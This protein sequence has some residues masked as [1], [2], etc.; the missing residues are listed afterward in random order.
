MPLYCPLPTTHYPLPLP[1]DGKA[2][3]FFFGLTE[4]SSSLPLSLPSP[5]SRLS[6]S[7]SSS[8]SLPPQFYST[9]LTY[10]YTHTRLPSTHSLSPSGVNAAHALTGDDTMPRW[11][12]ELHHV[13]ASP[14]EYP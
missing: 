4:K 2:F 1:T 12:C 13:A 3:F 5:V 8:L 9:N 7:F 11:L 14:Q 6:F 10:I